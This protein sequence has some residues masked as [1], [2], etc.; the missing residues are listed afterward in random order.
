MRYNGYC[1]RTIARRRNEDSYSE[2]S[3]NISKINDASGD[4][5]RQISR[6]GVKLA[7]NSLGKRLR[8][9]SCL[10]LQPRKLHDSHLDIAG[11]SMCARADPKCTIRRWRFPRHGAGFARR[12]ISFHKAEERSDPRPI[13]P[14]WL[15]DLKQRIGKCITFGL[16]PRQVEDAGSILQQLSADWARLVVGREGYL[17]GPG[18]VGLDKQAVVWGDMVYLLPSVYAASC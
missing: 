8:E 3:T 1:R 15:F 13:N 9:E 2:F 12:L 18:R 16:S 5:S 7:L 10:S 6:L 4:F 17:T 14:R 11:Y